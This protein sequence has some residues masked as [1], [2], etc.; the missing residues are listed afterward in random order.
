MKA[1][2]NNMK[3]TTLRFYFN[4]RRKNSQNIIAAYARC[5]Y[6]SIKFFSV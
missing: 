6:T 3:S 5:M 2:I 1:I 4:V